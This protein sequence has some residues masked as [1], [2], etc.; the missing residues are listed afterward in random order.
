MIYGNKSASMYDA[1]CIVEIDGD[2]Y[3]GRLR[4]AYDRSGLSGMDILSLPIWQIERISSIE[5][6]A[7]DPEVYMPY[8]GK[9]PEEI[10][11]S[12][13]EEEPE[14][15]DFSITTHMYPGGNEN[16]EFRM[17]LCASYNYQFRR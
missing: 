11:E 3:L 10:A 16:Y 9:T 17:D 13:A 5:E 6:E 1:D 2:I 8:E 15:K 4:A 14:T 12:Q 7:A